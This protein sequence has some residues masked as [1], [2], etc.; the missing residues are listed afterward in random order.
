M[1]EMKLTHLEVEANNVIHRVAHRPDAEI[2]TILQQRMGK[3]MTQQ[4][5]TSLI[6]RYRASAAHLDTRK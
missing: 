6:D 5:A 4:W 3:A 1:T 2:V